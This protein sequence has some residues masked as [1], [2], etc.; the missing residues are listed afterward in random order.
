MNF[1]P[2]LLSERSLIPLMNHSSL[3]TFRS[4]LQL[5]VP[6]SPTMIGLLWPVISRA[7]CVLRMKSYYS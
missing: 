6:E 7:V 5:I 4:V 1:V 3:E 2:S